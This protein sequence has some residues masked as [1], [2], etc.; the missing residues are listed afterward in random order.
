MKDK[1]RAILILAIS[2]L[3]PIVTGC[4]LTIHFRLGDSDVKATVES[5][6]ETKATVKLNPREVEMEVGQ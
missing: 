5:K 4:S 2:L 1:T 3:W 6:S